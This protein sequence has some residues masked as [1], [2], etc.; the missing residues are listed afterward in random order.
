MVAVSLSWWCG[1][2]LGAWWVGNGGILGALPGI[3]HDWSVDC[4]WFLSGGGVPGI[5]MWSGTRSRWWGLSWC[6]EV[7]VVMLVMS[8]SI[9]MLSLEKEL[10]LS[11]RGV[12]TVVVVMCIIVNAQPLGFLVGRHWIGSG[13][14]AIHDVIDSLIQGVHGLEDFSNLWVNIGLDCFGDGV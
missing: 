5:W 7:F 13:W 2:V 6:V 14:Q 11:P 8:S 12:W 9:S 1:Q 4:I 10:V 3:I